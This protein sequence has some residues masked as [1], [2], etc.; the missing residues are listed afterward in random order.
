MTDSPA[1]E[2]KT[3]LD[4]LAGAFFRAV[5]FEPGESPRYHEIF[6]L[7]VERGLLIKNVGASPEIASVR[8]FIEPREELVRSGTLTRFEEHEL[9]ESTAIF[10][11][12]AHRFSVYAKS[13]TSG[14]A[15][16]ATRGVVSTQF[17]HTP[18]GWKM[19]AMAWD[20]ERPG[21]SVEGWSATPSPAPGIQQAARGPLRGS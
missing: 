9:S 13:G 2:V 7:F 19:S 14:G 3:E 11:N 8:S 21:L 12:V 20:D 5:S 10:G 15:S 4:R 6:G 1:G 16:F 17:V 18:D